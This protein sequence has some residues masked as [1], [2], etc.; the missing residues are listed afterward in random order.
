[1][2]MLESS[3]RS[4]NGKND[5]HV[6][7]W[8]PEGPARGVVQIAHGVAEYIDRYDAFARCLAEH[9]FAV[10]GN[11]HLGH[12][13]SIANES[14][15]GWF[16][17]KDGWNL[18]VGDMKKLRD[19]ERDKFQGVPYFLLGHSMGSFLARTYIIRYP[20]DLDGVVISG[21]GWQSGP[22][23]AGGLLIAKSEICRHGTKYRSDRLDHM[24][25]GNYLNRIAEPA[26]QKD[27]LSR[28][29]QIVKKYVDDPLCGFVGTAGLMR[30]MMMGLDFIRRPENLNKM[31]KSLPVLFFSGAE[32]PV[33]GWSRGVSKAVAAFKSAGMQDVTVHLYDGGRHEMLNEVNKQEVWADV[34]GWLDG[35]V[36]SLPDCRFSDIPG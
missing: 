36:P 1:M 5:I 24:A 15:L 31:N 33:G 19:R 26:S 18:V 32:D 34:L 12:G 35:K 20:Y 9:G 11:D 30:D 22:V 3:F 2:K 8:L 17:E 13:K 6:A 27:W 25:Y 14:E 28:D 16:G 29:A 7:E 23:C 4:G 10:V 21:T